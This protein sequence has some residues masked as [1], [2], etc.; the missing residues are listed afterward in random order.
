MEEWHERLFEILQRDPAPNA[1][2]VTMHQLKE[3]EKMLFR[4]L[5]EKTRGKLSQQIDGTKPI[6]TF[7]TA[8]H[9]EGSFP[10]CSS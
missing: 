9:G 3:A 6:K 10:L 1:M 8:V 5:A 4:K 2:P 7:L